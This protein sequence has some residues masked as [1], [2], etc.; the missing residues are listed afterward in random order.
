[1]SFEGATDCHNTLYSLEQQVSSAIQVTAPEQGFRLYDFYTLDIKFVLQG[2]PAF[3]DFTI[4]D[5]RYF[6]IPFWAP[7]HDFEE[8][9]PDIFFVFQIFFFSENVFGF[10][11]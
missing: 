7:F 2:I 1:M 11:F 6:V 5:P 9:N 10:F 4:R 8:K 3:H